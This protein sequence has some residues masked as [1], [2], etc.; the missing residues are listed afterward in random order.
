MAH[1]HNTSLPVELTD[2]IIDFLHDDVT[3]LLACALVSH[4]WL[5][6]SRL[7]LFHS[8]AINDSKHFELAFYTIVVT[9]DVSVCVER[10]AFTSSPSVS[11]HRAPGTIHFAVAVV[12]AAAATNPMDSLIV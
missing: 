9:Q 6:S 4:S 7:H 1:R 10:S 12:A 11:S 3:S 5:P 8:Y 2:M